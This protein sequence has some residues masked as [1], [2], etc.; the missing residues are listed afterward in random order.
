MAVEP[1]DRCTG[2]NSV[3]FNIVMLYIPFVHGSDE[4]IVVLLLPTEYLRIHVDHRGASV[5]QLNI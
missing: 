2:I 1:R 5:D 3:F 4:I